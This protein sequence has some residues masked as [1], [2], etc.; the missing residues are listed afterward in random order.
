[1][2]L[3]SGALGNE[4]RADIQRVAVLDQK[5][6]PAGAGDDSY[7]FFEESSNSPGWWRD[8]RCPSTMSR[9]SRMAT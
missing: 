1:V 6:V 8:R 2:L 9:V 3:V 7:R 4:Q 5:L